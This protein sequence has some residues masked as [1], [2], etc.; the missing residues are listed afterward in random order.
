MGVIYFQGAVESVLD[1][2]KVLG[3]GD[4]ARTRD[5]RIVLV[6]AQ[7]LR[8]GILVDGV[9]DVVDWATEE[10]L[11]PLTTVEQNQKEYIAGE[12]DYHGRTLVVL[13][14]ALLFRRVLAE[15]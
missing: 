8:S 10:I 11:P 6:E 14:L 3:L 15:G 9:E 1:L 2:K 13:D 7:G 12:A 4:T 5:S